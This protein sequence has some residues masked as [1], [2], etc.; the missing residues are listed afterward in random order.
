MRENA[1]KSHHEQHGLYLFLLRGN[2]FNIIM[3]DN[4]YK[5]FVHMAHTV[6]GNTINLM[7][8]NRFPTRCAHGGP[9]AGVSECRSLEK[10]SRFQ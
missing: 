6:S 1:S 3:N 2:A 5:D 9:R 4:V 7:V 8:L 10:S